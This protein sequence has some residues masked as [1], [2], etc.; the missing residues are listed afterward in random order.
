MELKKKVKN[1][2]RHWKYDT[3]TWFRQVCKRK[4]F[5]KTITNEVLDSWSNEEKGK[6][7]ILGEAEVVR[8]VLNSNL[9]QIRRRNVKVSNGAKIRNRYNQVPHLT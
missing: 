8:H 6:C 5:D 7:S 9:D 3:W 2:Q 1:T 4:G